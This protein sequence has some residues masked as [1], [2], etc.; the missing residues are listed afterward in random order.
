M[1]EAQ[2]LNFL[3]RK[4]KDGEDDFLLEVEF[5]SGLGPVVADQLR[6]ILRGTAKLSDFPNFP[7]E[8]VCELARLRDSQAREASPK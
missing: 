7:E 5:Q 3:T 1:A 6:Q 2:I 4:E 8:R